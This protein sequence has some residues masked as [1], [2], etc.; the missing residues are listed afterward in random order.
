LIEKALGSVHYYQIDLELLAKIA[1][2]LP[3][4]F[5]L[6]R[7]CRRIRSQLVANRLVD[8]HGRNR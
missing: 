4:S 5:F 6:R 3:T 1:S 7:R 2:T 8:Q